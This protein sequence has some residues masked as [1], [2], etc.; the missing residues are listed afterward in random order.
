M[1][2][3]ERV[4]AD[5]FQTMSDFQNA[6]LGGAQSSTSGS[7]A[8]F[9][10]RYM[11]ASG[12][13]GAAAGAGKRRRV[14]IGA[15][16]G[17]LVLVVGGFTL[18]HYFGRHTPPPSSDANRVAVLY[19]ADETNGRWQYLADGLTESL[20]DR[21]SSI[22]ALDV[23]SKDGVRQ[24]RGTE[25]LADSIGRALQVGSVVRGTIETKGDKA[26]LNVRL[27]DAPSD[28]DIARASFDLDPTKIGAAEA[29][30]ASHVV[31]FLRER[32]GNEVRLRNDRAA[33]SSSDA[34]TLVERAN[35]MRKDSDSL[36]A[37]GARDAALGAL[38][39]AD[40]MLKTASNFDRRWA[41]IPALR[42]ATMYSRARLL[43]AD[44][45]A[46]TAAVDTGLAAADSALA[47]QP[48]SA[49]A[50]ETKGELQLLR[51]ARRVDTEPK[52]VEQLLADAEGNL[53]KS[54]D[55]NKDQAG[56]WA[57][58]SGLYYGKP[59]VQSANIAALN[60]YRAD[61]YLSSAKQVLARLF[62]TSYDLEQY[63]EALKW[64]DEGHRRYPTESIFATCRLWIYTTRLARPDV[65]SAWIYR[66][67]YVALASPE[68]KQ[69]TEK[70]GDILVAGALARASLPDSSR[71]VL[72]RAR[73]TPEQDPE[74]ELE[75]YEAVMRVILGDQDEAIRLIADYLTVH[76]SHRKGFAARV[77]PWWRDLQSNPK[78][79]RLM[80]GAR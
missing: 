11:T 75:G 9:T 53:T 19:F 2:A 63:P 16:I 15:G 31:D 55:L 56:A 14:A 76:P 69:F 7:A 44:P 8:R 38:S 59:D 78:F 52:T 50:Y 40:S 70:M 80:A 28:A 30:V 74:R 17:A 49:D 4:P 77:S 26:R 43:A 23:V 32:L 34:W 36:A 68:K 47:L 22:P 12:P 1:R 3:M 48:N 37:A 42:A 6:V 13:G 64:C 57:S 58:L 21:L 65:D 51:Y 18:A 60:A 29:E 24:F 10:P 66:G 61:A 35:R 46:F 73:A 27:V 72:L 54:V 79:R 67:Q 62:Q 45:P 33:T 25:L 39:R 71:R 20:I 41:R 5:R